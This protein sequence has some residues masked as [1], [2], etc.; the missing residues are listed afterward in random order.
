MAGGLLLAAVPAQ[1]A[2]VADQATISVRGAITCDEGKM[3]KQIADLR[4]KAF[5]LDRQGKKAAAKRARAKADA[6]AKK[7]KQCQDADEN[8]PGPI[9]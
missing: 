9:G 6:L 7:L 8:N 1:A 5:D 4:D 3:H 2:T